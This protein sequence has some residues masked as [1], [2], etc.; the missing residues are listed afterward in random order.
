MRKV[1]SIYTNS[2]GALLLA[3]AVA[4]FLINW[5]NPV[6]TVPPHDLIFQMP[7]NKQLWIMGGIAGVSALICFFIEWATMSA[8]L[9]LWLALNYLAVRIG[10]WF[11][12]NHSLTGYLGGFTYNFSISAN[13]TGVMADMFFIYLFIGGCLSL[14]FGRRLPAPVEFQKMSCPACGGHV[15]FPLRNLGQKVDCPHCR[16]TVAL[17]NP[18]ERLKSSC[19]FCYGHI[20]FP[21]HAVGAKIPCPHCK[22]DITLKASA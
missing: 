6:D 4:L 18:E 14:W 15:K 21:A 20:E 8:L 5:T 11:E 3:V 7:L 12:G 22:M 13:A 17:R 10:L 19:F 16:V 9:L 1:I 2:A